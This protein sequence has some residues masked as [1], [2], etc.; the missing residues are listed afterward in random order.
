MKSNYQLGGPRP[1]LFACN[2]T[3]ENMIFSRGLLLLFVLLASACVS[4]QQLTYFP[5]E[6]FTTEAP[7]YIAG[8][9]KQYHLQPND[10]LSVRIKTLDEETAA[11]FNIES[12]G[13]FQQFNPAGLYVNGYSLDS[14]GN[15]NL[16]EV[17]AVKLSGLTLE[18]A[19]QVIEKEISQFVNNATVL[20]RIVS[21]K[22]TVLGEVNNP[23]YYYVY[24]EQVTL[25]E[26]LGLAG[27]LTELGNRENITLI[28]QTNRGK[29]AILLNLKDSEMLSSA[30]YYL[31][32][33]DV[34]YVQPLRA[35]VV[36][37]NLSLLTVAGVVFGAISA[38]VL[39]L[40][41]LN[42]NPR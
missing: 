5:N 18:Q 32:P 1:S 42:P 4:T 3:K 16:P 9:P 17:G 25:L 30:Y 10:V 8:K 34:V 29:E 14:E 12:G 35:K 21:F 23:G 20:V 15:I 6:E 7:T 38:T 37:N 11:Y 40:N 26:A 19:Q 39:L 24:N 28:R 22:V 31:Q 13:G 33:N 27:D 2:K 36:R 41:Y